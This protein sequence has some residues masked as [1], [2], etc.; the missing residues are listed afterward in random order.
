MIGLCDCNNF[1]V[2]C[3]RVF[4]PELEGV[5]VVVLS[6][7]DGCVI[8]RSNESKA[9]GL[10]MGQ[11]LF[12]VQGLVKKYDIK[13]CSTNYV[14]YG[15]M[16]RRVMDTLRQE[17]PAIEVYS[18]DEAFIDYSGTDISKL[19]EEARE[20]SRVIRRNTG[21]P[22]SIGIAPTKTL[23]KI[24][25]KL[26]KKY[27]KLRGACLMY[28]EKDI[29]KV[30]KTYP[31]EDVWGIGR[32]YAATLKKHGIHTADQFRRMH[33]E[34]VKRNM[35]IVGLKVWQELNGTKS[36]EFET[37][38]PDKQSICVSRSFGTEIKSLDKLNSALMNYVSRAAEKLRMQGSV[39]GAMNVFIYTNRFRD[40]SEQHCESRL[41]KLSSPTDST[42][43]LAALAS[44][45]LT[46]L[47][48]N[49]FAYKKAGVVLSDISAKKNVQASLFDT[50]DRPK[51]NALM[52]T[53]DRVNKQ[54]GRG[55]IT[56]ASFGGSDNAFT[57][58]EHC[59]PNYT[60]DINDII[61]VKV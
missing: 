57:N 36:I 5:P 20:T 37:L 41:V 39:A 26:C 46:F 29:D 17:V 12:Q 53:I 61:T 38:R 44:R 18:V 6:S 24:A 33:P 43:E 15:D 42:L 13:L 25:S 2:S 8:A 35:S 54:N 51:H 3:E 10:K 49:G 31:I 19:E 60:T 4:R 14:L 59:S 9:L 50:I 30:L 48:R 34:W 21:I 40:V 32:R 52:Q 16:S 27:P 11:P 45:E 47:F 7:N 58:S 28:R 55:T 22:V 1:F 56:L 23:A